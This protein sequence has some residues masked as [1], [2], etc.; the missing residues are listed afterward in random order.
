M[1][2]III[3]IEAK[4]RLHN[5]PIEILGQLT[6]KRALTLLKSMLQKPKRI[7]IIFVRLFKRY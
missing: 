6:V 1:T 7:L 2:T 5:R 4:E 3:I